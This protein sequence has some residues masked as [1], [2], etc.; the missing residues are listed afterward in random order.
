VLL[1]LTDILKAAFVGQPD[2]IGN[3]MAMIIT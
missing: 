1:S 2:L 3:S